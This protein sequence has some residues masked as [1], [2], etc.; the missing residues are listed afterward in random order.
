MSS[1]ADAALLHTSLRARL[2]HVVLLRF[3]D[4]ID[5]ATVAAL[6]N[7]FVA[8]CDA[9]PGVRALEWGRNESP[10]GLDRGFTHAF[11]LSFDG[12]AARDAYLVH[13]AHQAFVARLQPAL[14]DVLVVDYRA[15]GAAPQ[16]AAKQ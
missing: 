14:A 11:T 4:G 12:C 13:P 2:R 7:D 5:E 15:A 3:A 9:V 8:L 6:C 1:H 10:E 16:S